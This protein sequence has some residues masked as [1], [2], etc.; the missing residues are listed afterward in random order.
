MKSNNLVQ[1]L[2]IGG[3]IVAISLALVFAEK[4]DIL[5]DLMSLR[6]TMALSGLVVAYFGNAIP[7][8]VFRSTR[9]AALQRFAGWVF[10]VTGLVYAAAWLFTPLAIA[11]YAMYVIGAGLA[12]VL[13]YCLWSRTAGRSQAQ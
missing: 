13:A 11:Y 2:I 7:K 10:V 9:A 6:I 1:G 12:L 5:G 8:A 4:A 3:G